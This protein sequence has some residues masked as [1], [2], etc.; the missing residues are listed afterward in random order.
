MVHV[1]ALTPVTRPDETSTVATDGL[2]LLHAPV[3]PPGTSAYVTGNVGIGGTVNISGLAIG[4]TGAGTT[5]VFVD[6]SG[7]LYKNILG[8]GAFTNG[9]GTTYSATNGLTLS[10]SNQFGLG[11]TLTQNT[12]IGTSNNSLSFIGLGG[13]Q[14]LFIGASG[15][16]GI[17]T[18]APGSN[19]SISNNAQTSY[20]Q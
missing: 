7:N 8:A 1:P 9:I 16:V 20:F 13:T 12:Q 3:P 19:L 17:G 2:L 18:T 10:G 6:T 15:Y 14:S 11:G 5:A 4:N